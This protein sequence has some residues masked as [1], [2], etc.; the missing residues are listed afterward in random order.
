M[1]E[2]R[3]VPTSARCTE[4]EAA[5]G[6]MPAM[7]SRVLEVTPYAMPKDPSTSWAASPTNAMTSSFRTVVAPYLIPSFLVFPISL[8]GKV[9]KARHGRRKNW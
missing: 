5:A 9:G 8:I 4:A 3:V 2:A 7:R 1:P 6:E